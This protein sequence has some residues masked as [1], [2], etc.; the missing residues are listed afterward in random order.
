MARQSARNQWQSY[1]ERVGLDLSELLNRNIRETLKV[2][3]RAVVTN[4][5]QDSGR[6][7]FHWV[8]IPN[9]GAVNPGKWSEMTFNP[10]YYRPPIGGPGDKGKNRTAVIQAVISRETRK[11][12][13]AT[14]KG[15]TGQ[16]TVFQFQS[17]VP[18]QQVDAE[19]GRPGSRSNYRLNAEL[20]KAKEAAL[21]QMKVKWEQQIAAGNQR[22]RP[23]S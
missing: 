7:A 23:V 12:I 6:A 4:T 10:T 21:T 9:R 17:N 5:V 18:S 3:V 14:V 16:A 11:T 19:W 8:I 15:R 13:D 20:A 22:K 1:A 2:G